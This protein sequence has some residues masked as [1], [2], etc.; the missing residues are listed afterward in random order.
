M[1][2]YFRPLYLA[3]LGLVLLGISVGGASLLLRLRAADTSPKE[4]DSAASRGNAAPQRAVSFGHV[5]VDG[6]LI[7]L[8]P[9]Q[10]GRVTEVLVRED[11]SVQAGAILFRLEDRP[12]KFLV[13][14]AQAD[15]KAAQAQLAEARKAP[16]QHQSKIAQQKQV[17]E[18]MRH[19]LESARHVLAHKRDLLQKK[20][21]QSEEEIAAADEQVK[22][23]ESAEKA[24]QEKLR[25]LE[26]LDPNT[27]I[28][29]A[30]ADV[31]AKESKV[32][33]ARFALEE[34]SLRA[35]SAGKILR[36]FVNPGD[37][38]GSNSRQ[39][40]IQFCPD[41]PRIVRAE[42]EQEFAGRVTKGQAALVHD[43]SSAGPGWKGKVTR[44]SD[45]YTAR[46]SILQE[47]LQFN[48]VRTLECIVE[49]DPGQQAPKIGQR[50]RVTFGEAEA[51]K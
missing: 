30:E 48:D 39:P 40:A 24:E 19:E 46:R 23:L 16:H 13:D 5:D 42:V 45:W 49:L 33:Q 34:C 7:S 3:I 1:K 9:L 31:A 25:E 50:V 43:D 14:Q 51:S 2:N 27:K 8:C 10:P 4:A 20:L 22:K 11:E 47:P 35:P 36:I 44:V 29:Q 37:V 6:G 18:A 21:A 12:A 28:S 15:V 26:L 41:K 38:L 32:E 17:I